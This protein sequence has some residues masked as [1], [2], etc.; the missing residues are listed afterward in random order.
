MECP[1]CCF[2]QGFIGQYVR[3]GVVCNCDTNDHIY[4][5]GFIRRSSFVDDTIRLFSSPYGGNITFATCC[6]NIFEIYLFDNTSGVASESNK[7]IDI[8]SMEEQ[9]RDLLKL[10]LEGNLQKEEIA[11]E[12]M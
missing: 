10:A 1:F 5:D 8:K 4:W 12:E 9:R 7:K 11:H 6:D 2:L 3:I